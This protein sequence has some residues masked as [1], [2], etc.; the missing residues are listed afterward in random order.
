[1]TRSPPPDRFTFFGPDRDAPYDIGLLVLHDGSPDAWLDHFPT[2]PWSEDPATVL[3][4]LHIEQ[5]RGSAALARAEARLHEAAGLRGWVAEIAVPRGIVDLGRA[6]ESR[7]RR[8]V[9][10]RA[11]AEVDASVVRGCDTHVRIRALA[12]RTR[13]VRDV[14]TMSPVDPQIDAAAD[15]VT[16]LVE[17]P[18]DLAACARRWRG[19]TAQRSLDL[20]EHITDRDLSMLSPRAIKTLRATLG[21]LGPV[22]VNSPYPAASFV[23]SPS[24]FLTGRRPVDS[25]LATDVPKS[26]L[27]RPDSPFD[28][29]NFAL[30]ADRVER[31]ATAHVHAA[32]WLLDEALAS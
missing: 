6:V 21:A 23:F 10:V 17:R 3:D 25:V 13:L 2:L 14:H 30:D 31:I 20:I 18:G 15:H 12:S 16:P 32:R 22:D 7:M 8:H 11:V 26:W 19:G 9:F 27:A 28:V 29:A 4:W 5:D 24:L 1:M